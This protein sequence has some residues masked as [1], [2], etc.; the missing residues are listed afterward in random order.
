MKFMREFNIR[1][2]QCP[3]I[4]GKKKKIKKRERER[5]SYCTFSL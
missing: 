3:T 1:R 2:I 5:E 4:K